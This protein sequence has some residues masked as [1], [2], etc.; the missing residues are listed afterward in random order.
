[1]TV[2][3]TVPGGFAAR[4]TE[5]VTLTMACLAPWAFGSVEAWAQ[6]GLSLGVLVLAALGVVSAWSGKPSPRPGLAG[7]ALAGLAILAVLQATTIPEGL[8]RVVAPRAAVWRAGLIPEAPERVLGDKGPIVPLPA[9]TISQDPESSWQVAARLA[10]AWVLLRAGASLGGF[11]ALRRFGLMTAVNAAVMGLFGLLQAL[12]WNGKIYG[13]RASPQLDGW[14]TGGPFVSHGHLAAY[15]NLGLG[16]ALG[17]LLTSA[18][19][20]TGRAARV[21]WSYLSAL[22]LVGLIGSHSRGGVL[23]ASLAAVALGLA[24]RPSRLRQAVWP[25][26]VVGLVALIL[27]VLGDSSPFRRLTTILDL[28]DEGYQFRLEI[29][30]S[31]LGAWR[32][33]P[34]LGCGLGTFAESAA[35]YFRRDYGMRF[36]RAENEVIDLLV[37]GGLVG[38]G[39]AMAGLLGLAGSAR[40]AWRLAPSAPA[41]GLVAGGVFGLL[42]ISFHSASDFAPHVPGVAMSVV[43]LAGHLAGAAGVATGHRERTRPRSLAESLAVLALGVVLVGHDG[44]R[45]LAEA[46]LADSGLNLPGGTPK[47]ER[48]VEHPVEPSDPERLQQAL[49]AALRHRPDWAEGHLRRGFA[50]LECYRRQAAQWIRE[51]SDGE[52]AAPAPNEAE[53]LSDPL[54]LHGVAHEV[55]PEEL[56]SVGGLLGQGPVVASLVP[57]ARCFLEARR[58][59][60]GLPKAQAGLATLDFL[61]EG[62]DPGALYADRALRQAGGDAETAGRVARVGAQLG[63]MDLAARGWRLALIARPDDWRHVAE[64]TALVFDPATIAARVLPD[65][66]ARIAWNFAESLGPGPDGAVNREVFLRRALQ[67][68][69]K[70]QSLS[71]AERSRTEGVAL[72]GLGR[73]EKARDAMAAALAEAPSRD[74]WRGEL[75]DWLI[76]WGEPAEARREALIG[77]HLAGNPA[78]ALATLQ[79]AEEALANAAPAAP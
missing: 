22:I 6:L 50:L 55:S 32:E 14:M 18:R 64:V 68:L 40:R 48:Q 25:M 24:L 19:S 28:G 39:L 31:S 20:S 17:G 76:A 4:A 33:H 74:D 57:A 60:P 8:L 35:P 73:R 1:M 78:A 29:W 75:V 47:G 27:A 16:F 21:G 42:A 58:C 7:T 38:L 46:T 2:G 53:A 45:A 34:I 37:E 72:A 10:G 62:A 56:A 65:D 3:K 77:L 71:V 43:L 30:R 54:W 44:P 52:T 61:L 9:P 23:A 79:R 63:E 11:M 12:T 67:C 26:V 13:L 66:D 41:R 51:D 69:A 59:A 15:L 5:A 49:A 36:A 70:D